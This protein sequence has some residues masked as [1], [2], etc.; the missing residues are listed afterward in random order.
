[1]SYTHELLEKI[2]AYQEF[3]KRAEARA[4]EIL[5]LF[6][7]EELAKVAEDYA[8]ATSR[9]QAGQKNIMTATGWTP[10][11]SKSGYDKAFSQ[12][13]KHNKSRSITPAN[14]KAEYKAESF[15]RNRAS[16]DARHR[17]QLSTPYGSGALPPYKVHEGRSN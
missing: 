17:G 4:F 15:K 11:S 7:E 10:G 16:N 9:Q 12:N 13:L 8:R 1:M 6:D 3:E 14:A 2:A 5:E